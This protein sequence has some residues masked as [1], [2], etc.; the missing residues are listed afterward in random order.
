MKKQYIKPTT[1]T[2]KVQGSNTLMSGSGR[3]H[4]NGS[5]EGIQPNKGFGIDITWG[6]SSKQDTQDK[7][8]QGRLWAD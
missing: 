2:L 6:G 7:D 4:R 8:D 3:A 5:V 1:T